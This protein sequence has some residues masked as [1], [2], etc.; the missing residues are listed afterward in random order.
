ML[1]V[2]YQPSETPEGTDKGEAKKKRLKSI[3]SLLKGRKKSQSLTKKSSEESD[4][5]LGNLYGC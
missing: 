3:S 1:Y 2:F 5:Q 4:E